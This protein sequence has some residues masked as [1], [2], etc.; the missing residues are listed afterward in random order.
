[1]SRIGKMPVEI[2][3]GVKIS[4]VDG[5]LQVEGPK[6]KLNTPLPEG[7]KAQVEEK[8]VVLERRDDSRNQRAQHGLARA[9]LSNSVLGVTEGF[10]KRLD[11][12][13]V[14]YRAEVSGPWLNLTLGYSHPVQ[15]PIPESFE[16]S[17]DKSGK[18]AINQY[19]AT[20]I[21]KGPDKAAVGQYAADIRSLRKPDVYK[22]KGIRYEGEHI[23]L[24]VGKK[25]A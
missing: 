6:G 1:M 14:G 21:I 19:V 3:S 9:L 20:L 12:V 10:E 17:V 15:V 11:V 23:K 22:G 5:A 18:K 16:V 2:P 13:G 7:I 24:K 8:E 25:G 4:V